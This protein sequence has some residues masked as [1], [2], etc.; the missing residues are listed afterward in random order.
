M[1]RVFL[2]QDKA[3][4]R[5]C[6]A[7]LLERRIG[8]ECIQVG[9]FAEA[10]RALDHLQGEIDLAIVDIDLSDGDGVEIV[11]RLYELWFDVPVLVL[12]ADRSLERRT[13]ALEA[14]ADEAIGV[15]TYADNLVDAIKTLISEE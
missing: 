12:T 11:E 3:L 14:G 4:F 7:V 15:Q 6:L 5:G 8:L 2:V 9:S 13:R 10:H 1:K